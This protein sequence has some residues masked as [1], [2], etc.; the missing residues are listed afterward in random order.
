MGL[1]LVGEVSLDGSGFEAGL[2][3]LEDAAGHFWSTLKGVALEAFGIYTI[4]QAFAKTV[5]TAK[6]LVIQSQR[7]SMS[8]E[9]LQ[10]MRQ[11]AKENNVE[12][13]KLSKTFEA[14]DVAREKALKNPKGH[15]AKRFA[16]LG[17]SPADL[18]GANSK[19]AS[20]LFMGPMHNAAMGMNA[21][22]LDP[23]L[24]DFGIKGF[25]QLIPLLTTD[26][27]ELREKM[28]AMG[29]IMSTKT[30]VSLKLL[31]DEMELAGQV[32]IAQLAP[33]LVWLT[34]KLL[35]FAAVVASFTA[36]AGGA[37]GALVPDTKHLV[38]LLVDPFNIW[39]K[40]TGPALDWKAAGKAGRDATHTE[41]AKWFD[42]IM[43]FEK[44][45]ADLTNRANKPPGAGGDV[46]PDPD[47]H[48][49]GRHHANMSEDSM[50]RVGNFLGSSA[51][52]L[53]GIA[54]QQLDVLKLIER[55]T[56][57]WGE[58]GYSPTEMVGVPP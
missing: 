24:K 33:A 38:K 31:S 13:E 20:E 49:V 9:G 36:G 19:L 48:S 17:I 50:I 42:G 40:A 44:R 3:K 15:E 47:H 27:E 28:E 4:E 35:K 18:Q 39:G 25:G 52:P 29:A 22:Q 57:D 58:V 51:S 46:V 23:I 32:I 21:Q 7:L 11:A 12:M 8:V 26:F 6:E 30:A 5:E 55:N 34:D 56:R 2:N 41:F 37:A 14:I 16:Q 53:E 1:K 45:I 10:V 43:A 54:T